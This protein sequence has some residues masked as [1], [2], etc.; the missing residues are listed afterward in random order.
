MD[1]TRRYSN[2]SNLAQSVRSEAGI[3]PLQPVTGSLE[4]LPT[5]DPNL[6]QLGNR[7]R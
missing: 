2:I 5:L 6:A 3:N 4:I 1:G 7:R